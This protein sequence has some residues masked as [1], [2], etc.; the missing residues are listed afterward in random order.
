MRREVKGLAIA[1]A[2]AAGMVLCVTAFRLIQTDA[3]L[4]SA[5]RLLPGSDR[6]EAVKAYQ[7][8][9]GHRS[10]GVTADLYFSRAWAQIAARSP[11]V[12]S[13]LYF[14]QMAAES[15]ALAVESPEQRQNGWYNLAELAAARE[16]GAAVETSLRGAIEAAPNWFKPHWALARLLYAQGRI[17]E[18]QSEARRVADLYAG[19]DAEVSTSVA[20]ILSPHRS[21]H[22]GSW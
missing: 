2:I 1:A 20:E 3:A 4:G 17:P 21:Q 16:D 11:D 5:Q 8:A 15:A 14:S 22:P 10:S 19:Q 9:V 6:R 18:A 7:R 12:L 13:R